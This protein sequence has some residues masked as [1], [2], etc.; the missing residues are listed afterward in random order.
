[1]GARSF[2]AMRLYSA[3]CALFVLWLT[4]SPVTMTN[5]GLRRLAVAMANSKFAVS[6][7]K[8]AF[9]VYMPNCGS[10]IWMKVGGTATGG[11]GG[12]KGGGA[13]VCA[14]RSAAKT[15]SASAV[16]MA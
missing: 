15:G 12:T 4:R 5:A 3:T 7:A 1:M 6:W 9:F 11:G 14:T 10:D 8:S 16:F 13:M 2:A